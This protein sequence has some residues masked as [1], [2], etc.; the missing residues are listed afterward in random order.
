MAY[1]RTVLCW[2]GV[3]SWHLATW[4]NTEHAMTFLTDILNLAILLPWVIGVGTGLL[5]LAL[6]L[7]RQFVPVGATRQYETMA[8]KSAN[9][10]DLR[11]APRAR[12]AA[13]ESPEDIFW[14]RCP[15][16]RAV[17][18]GE[19][20]AALRRCGDTPLPVWITANGKNPWEGGIRDRSTTGL[21][22]LVPHAVRTGTTLLV[23]SPNAPE[24]SPWVA[25]DVCHCR[26]AE[27]G[28]LLGCQF[29]QPQP[30]SVL[31]LFG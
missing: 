2:L 12:T 14:R 26:P 8:R 23:R 22:L 21:C 27:D 18:P 17:S 9:L 3:H 29:V 6:V 7:R 1:L 4:F 30:W 19:R 31:L 13:M 28:F 25:I 16:P 5:T 15:I 10:R 24:G 11:R 20:R